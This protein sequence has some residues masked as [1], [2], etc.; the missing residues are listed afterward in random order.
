[1]PNLVVLSQALYTEIRREKWAH[2]LPPSFKVT[3]NRHRSIGYLRLRTSDPSM[4]LS[5][6]VSDVDKWWF[7]CRKSQTF[8]YRTCI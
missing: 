4:G 5:R 7:Q 1:M 2:H 8:S 3:R 6:A